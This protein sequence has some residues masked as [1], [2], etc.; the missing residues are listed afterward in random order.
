MDFTLTA[1]QVFIRDTLRKF[2]QRDC[3]REKAHELDE[4]KAGIF[5]KIDT[6]LAKIAEI[7]FCGLNTPESFDGG[8]DDLLGTVVA[9]EEIAASAPVLAI[10]FAS[11][12]VNGGRV[13]SHF[14][15]QRQ[16]HELLPLVVQGDLKF[17]FAAS[18]VS[19]SGQ[20]SL[21]VEPLNGGYS[22]N[23]STPQVLLTDPGGAD[24]F[25][26]QT[27]GGMIFLIPRQTTGLSVK[28][29]PSV[30]LRGA[31]LGE[32]LFAQVQVSS[33]QILGG[34][35]QSNLDQV[36]TLTALDQISGA[37]IGLG[38]AAGAYQYT[39][40]YARERS[41]FGQTLLQFEAIEHMLVDWAVSLQSAR[42][43]LYHACWLAD[44]NKPFAVEAGM[45]RLQ[46]GSLARQ[47]GLQSVH[48]LGGYGY[49][50]EYDAQRAMRDAL[51]IFPGGLSPDL[52][53]TRIGKKLYNL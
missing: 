43:L 37:A 53:K 38:I 45:A 6:L 19:A 47:A 34:A 23:G 25:L 4:E 24:Y 33:E 3:P 8:G 28:S 44:Q 36:E 1:D 14:G 51:V 26:V 12:C 18:A 15:S 48:I 10:W 35:E 17:S 21:Q 22:L 27:A 46:T 31:G 39:L 13:L 16:Q 9:I 50:A 42:W 49:M 29:T 40:Q 20:E 2:M 32:V 52:L 7:G 30:G 11:V 5:P 41:Q